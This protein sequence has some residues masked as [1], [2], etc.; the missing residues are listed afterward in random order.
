MVTLESIKDV[1]NSFV[2]IS[3]IHYSSLGVTGRPVRGSLS[4]MAGSL[5]VSLAPSY[6]SWWHLQSR[7][8]NP[9]ASNLPIVHTGG[10]AGVLQHWLVFQVFLSKETQAHNGV[11]HCGVSSHA[12]A[13]CGRP[14]PESIENCS[15]ARAEP[16]LPI[17]SRVPPPP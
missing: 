14:C 8:E 11:G 3:V 16:V 12:E 17:H 7:T 15:S 5:H 2:F 4:C 1:F 6:T 9:V 13:G 10:L